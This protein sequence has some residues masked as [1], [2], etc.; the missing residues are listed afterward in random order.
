MLIAAGAIIINNLSVACK[1]HN[2]L[3]KRS[4]GRP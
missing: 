2:G 4:E 1:A 3:I